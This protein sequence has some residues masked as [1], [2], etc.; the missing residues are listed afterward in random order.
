MTRLANERRPV[1]G[2]GQS[3][4]S[5][6]HHLCA[7][8]TFLRLSFRNFAQNCY[9]NVICSAREKN[10]N[11]QGRRTSSSPLVPLVSCA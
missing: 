9:S 8:R 6:P 5:V 10:T 4:A 2:A 3:R 7:A 11:S 1:R